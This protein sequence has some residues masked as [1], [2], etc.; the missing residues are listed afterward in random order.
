MMETRPQ[1]GLDAEVMPT[2]EEDSVNLLDLLVRFLVK[3]RTLFVSFA[4]SLLIGVAL[5]YRIKP[6]Y[7][8][9]VSFAPSQSPQESNSLAAIFGGHRSGD[10]YVGLLQSRAVRDNVI[11][12]LDLRKVYRTESQDAARGLLSAS[13]KIF[14]GA[15]SIISVVV[16][17]E[18]SATATRVAN[19]Y[20]DA[21]E[22]QQ[23]VMASSQSGQRRR[24]YAKQ[25]QQ[26][27]DALAAAEEDLRKTQESLGIVQIQQQTQIGLSAIADI[28]AQIKAS[29]VRLSSLLL[30]E[31]E[32]NPE[33][34]SLRSEITQMQTQE[35]TLEAGASGKSPGAAMPAGRMPAAN[36][37][38]QRKER[39]VQY[40]NTLF[41]SLARELESARLNEAQGSETFQVVDRAV[42]PEF[43]AWPPR[44][45]LLLLVLA[46]SIF[47]SLVAVALH[48]LLERILR[49]PENQTQIA[50]L[51]KQL[52]PGD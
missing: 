50:A 30:S 43:K 8:A 26:E 49:D 2:Y 48:M 45:M 20:L 46:A 47:I 23:D 15:D 42:E 9:N 38:Y 18:N 34:R 19:T 29:Q 28:R 51:R 35:H 10:I 33:V 12:R 16:R 44:K 40:H 37:E 36:L 13:T 24:F 14:V 3:W 22:D 32:Q 39:E 4:L 52:H 7:E 31:T 1:F 5:V 25:L 17:D 27:K 6:L 41:N 11:R 21:L